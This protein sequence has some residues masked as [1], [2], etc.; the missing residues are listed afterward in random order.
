MKN[1]FIFF[2]GF[3][4]LLDCL[5][6]ICFGE[7]YSKFILFKPFFYSHE[8]IL[9]FVSI[10]SIFAIKKKG[11]RI[12]GIEILFGLAIL[13]LF[14]S[15]LSIN[16]EV[17]VYYVFRQFMIF[18]YGILIYFIIKKFYTFEEV[19]KRIS[20]GVA[21]F[22]ILCLIIQVLYIIYF[23][24]VHESLPFFDRNYYSP[25]IILGLIV[26][27]S[28]FMT[29]VENVYLKHLCFLF[30]FFVSFSIGHDSIYLSIS[31]IY[32]AYLFLSAGK[33]VQII[34]MILLIICVLL[35]M[36]FIQSFTDINMQWRMIYWKDSISR[37]I[38]NYFI[39]G[40]GFGTPYVSLEG[41]DKLNTLVTSNGYSFQVLREDKYLIAPHNSFLTMTIHLGI[42]P[43]ILLIFPLL[44]LFKQKSLFEDNEIMFL[45]LS[46]FGIVVFS[47]FNV[48]LEL[49]HSSSVFWIIYFVLIFKL[50]AKSG[51]FSVKEKLL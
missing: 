14:I 46:L 44:A 5:L 17:D 16:K 1:I 50:I 3:L 15:L 11:N 26:A 4:F 43:L 20:L 29:K 22:G 34:L 36:M 37:L 25:M 35:V 24:L 39:F 8:A 9:L 23:S 19:E 18:G 45:F 13:Y 48:I 27:S 40:E 38:D 41:A 32:F 33:K 42:I 30:V 21:F 28:Y 49:P 6:Q 51:T 2:L 7:T 12:I 31:L 10:G 47:S